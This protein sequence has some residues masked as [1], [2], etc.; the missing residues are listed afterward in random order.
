MGMA[1]ALGHKKGRIESVRVAA[2][3]FGIFTIPPDRDP[4]KRFFSIRERYNNPPAG[5]YW[6]CHR[7]PPYG[8]VSHLP[9]GKTHV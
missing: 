2:G 4:V 1:R 8:G 3:F 7:T 9:E 5:V 6:T